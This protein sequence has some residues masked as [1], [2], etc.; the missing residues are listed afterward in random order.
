MEKIIYAKIRKDLL[1]KNLSVPVGNTY[2]NKKDC[3]PCRW[4]DEDKLEVFLNKE[5][6]SAESIDFD[7]V[8]DITLTESEFDEKY[9]IVPNHFY[10]NPED[11]VECLKLMAKN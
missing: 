8:Y 4:V 11:L 3:L 10:D 1:E 9:H 2:Y 5:W 6:L 7:F